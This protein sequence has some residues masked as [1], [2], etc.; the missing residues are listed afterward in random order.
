MEAFSEPPQTLTL[1]LP[2]WAI[3]SLAFIL[4]TWIVFSLLMA[5]VNRLEG[6]RSQRWQHPLSHSNPLDK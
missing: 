4:A 2:N 1:F 6:N 5:A 3:N